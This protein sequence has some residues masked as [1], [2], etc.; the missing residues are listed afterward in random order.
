MF[1]S[2]GNLLVNPN[3]GLF[4]AMFQ[5]EAAARQWQRA[6][7]DSIR[8]LA[9]RSA[10]SSSCGSRRA[11]SSPIARF[12]SWR[13]WFHRPHAAEMRAPEPAWKSFDPSRTPHPRQPTGRVVVLRRSVTKTNLKQKI[14]LHFHF[15]LSIW[16][17]FQVARINATTLSYIS[18]RKTVDKVL[19]S[20]M[21]SPLRTP[22][23]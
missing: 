3:I 21:Q 7:S 19:E 6:V 12:I 11:P 2:L 9:R 10:R 23:R 8:R 15:S 13:R 1:K 4:I 20:D 22:A 18:W 16:E 5:A 14:R 17:R